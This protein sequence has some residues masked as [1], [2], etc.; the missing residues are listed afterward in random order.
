MNRKIERQML[1]YLLATMFTT[2]LFVVTT[3]LISIG[4][5]ALNLLESNQ[6]AIIRGLQSLYEKTELPVAELLET[7]PLIN[8]SAVVMQSDAIAELPQHVLDE[9]A[10]G[11]TSYSH[12]YSTSIVNIGGE[13][14]MITA[15][16]LRQQL[17]RA[18]LITATM[19]MTFF[20]AGAFMSSVGS[21]RFTH[22]IVHLSRATRT[23]AGGDFS[24][25][26][27]ESS[28]MPMEIRDL[29][30]NFNL[31]VRELAKT[32]TLR[33]DFIHAVSHEFKTPLAAI[34]GYATYAG[35]P[36]ISD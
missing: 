18:L 31:M 2:S 4:G 1:K 9:L 13:T 6:N 23:V 15:F 29:T 5:S 7:Y 22:S 14:V 35:T 33:K 16:P 12:I 34:R 19:L 11:Q 3:M 27:Q 20:A 36:G 30:H 24:V 26:V 21:R 32:S 17:M 8:H 25:Q 28:H 10:A